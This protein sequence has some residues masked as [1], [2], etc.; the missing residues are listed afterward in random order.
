LA[1]PWAAVVGQGDRVLIIDSGNNRVQVIAGLARGTWQT[2]SG[3]RPG[4]APDR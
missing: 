4:E 2:G 1:Y 3:P